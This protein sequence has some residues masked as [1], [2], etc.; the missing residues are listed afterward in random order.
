MKRA[1]MA[2]MI[3][4]T[5]FATAF[6]ETIYVWTDA[7]NI[8][9]FSDRPPDG[10]EY[11]EISGSSRPSASVEERLGYD[12]MVEQARVNSQQYELEK[13][14]KKRE[15]QVQKQEQM[16]TARRAH[17]QAQRQVLREQIKALKDRALSPTFSQGMRDAQIEVLE[18]KIAQLE[19]QENNQP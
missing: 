18:K 7:N 5:M 12:L 15:A 8:M 1:L 4:L 14:Q 10:I 13:Q 2:I 6:A 16:L 11:S 17:V 19:A 9:H 3:F